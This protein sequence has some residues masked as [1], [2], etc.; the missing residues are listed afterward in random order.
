MNQYHVLW[1]DDQFIELEKEDSRG[2]VLRNQEKI[3]LK[4]CAYVLASEYHLMI[5][6]V[7]SFE[8]FSGKIS[9]SYQAVIFDLRSLNKEDPNDV[10][11]MPKA[12]E[13]IRKKKLSIS[14]FVCSNVPDDPMFEIYFKQNGLVSE[15]EAEDNGLKQTV[16]KK[17]KIHIEQ[18][19][20]R[21]KEDVDERRHCF[22]GH[23]Y[24]LELFERGFLDSDPRVIEAMQDVLEHYSEHNVLYNPYNKMRIVVEDMLEQLVSNNEIPRNI[25]SVNTVSKFNRRVRY[26]TKDCHEKEGSVKGK[27]EID[28]DNPLYPFSK[29]SKEIKYAID[30]LG[31]MTNNGSHYIKDTSDYFEEGDSFIESNSDLQEATYRVFF[32]TMKWYLGRRLAMTEEENRKASLQEQQDRF[33]KDNMEKPSGV[34]V[35]GKIDLSMFKKPKPKRER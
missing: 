25:D 24:C 22:S 15:K 18:L 19:F 33:L 23:P 7:S 26:L 12:L 4:E 27:K 3:L 16:F 8:E 28:Y 2:A 32:L 11:V 29:C 17:D 34:K 10:M 9:N 35:L 31:N 20:A 14:V 13:I 6:T 5:D 30:F 21:I 1:L